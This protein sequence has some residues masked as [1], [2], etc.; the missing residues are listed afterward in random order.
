MSLGQRTP[1]FG[2]QVP[3]QCWASSTTKALALPCLL[4]QLVQKLFDIL[5]DELRQLENLS[6][7]KE[8]VAFW[9]STERSILDLV[10]RTPSYLILSKLTVANFSSY[11]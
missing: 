11:G 7:C 2:E 9:L 5:I 8:I 10:H 6:R 4:L 1:E 3:Q